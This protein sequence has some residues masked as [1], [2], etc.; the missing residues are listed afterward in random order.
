MARIVLNAGRMAAYMLVDRILRR[1]DELRTAHIAQATAEPRSFESFVDE[2]ADELERYRA[3][4][5]NRLG[6]EES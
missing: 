1:A 2:A 4:I 5:V 6:T 3:R